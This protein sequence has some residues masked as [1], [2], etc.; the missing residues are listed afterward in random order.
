MSAHNIYVTTIP[1]FTS[2]S[3]LDAVWNIAI[4]KTA[5][6]IKSVEGLESSKIG[7]LNGKTRKYATNDEGVFA[8]ELVAPRD[9][10][11][12]EIAKLP[13]DYYTIKNISTGKYL[14]IKDGKAEWIYTDVNDY[15][16]FRA[17]QFVDA[18]T[19]K[20]VFQLAVGSFYLNSQSPNFTTGD[21]KDASSFWTIGSEAST[22]G[23]YDSEKT[24]LLSFISGKWISASAEK[25]IDNNAN[26]CGINQ[27]FKIASNEYGLTVLTALSN[28]FLLAMK[29][30]QTSVES[31]PVNFNN[32]FIIEPVGE[33]GFRL[34]SA[35]TGKYVSSN[36]SAFVSATTD[37]STLFYSTTTLPKAVKGSYDVIGTGLYSMKNLV[38]SS[39]Q[40]D[41]ELQI[42]RKLY[43]EWEMVDVTQSWKEGYYFIKSQLF[44][45]YLG[46][47]NGKAS[48][49][50]DVNTLGPAN[51]IQIVPFGSHLRLK[52][53]DLYLS[54]E[55]AP[56][57]TKKE[58]DK[59]TLFTF[60]QPEITPVVKP[61][62]K[63]GLYSVDNFQWASCQPGGQLEVNRGDFKEWEFIEVEASDKDD[64]YYF[65]ATNFNKYLTIKDGKASFEP[66][67]TANSLFRISELKNRHFKMDVNDVYLNHVAPNFTTTDRSDIVTAKWTLRT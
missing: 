66:T 5:E 51:Y 14:G 57:Y 16:K 2:N 36:P 32:Y 21:S 19:S 65:K 6:I 38:W 12:V 22:I 49:K 9:Q 17:I 61:T 33:T 18:K 39:C 60:T 23:K 34:K 1:P 27:E 3:K 31:A 15:D 53:G 55:N 64:H 63:T 11:F 35:V 29:G 42:D 40:P 24:C 44:N 20:P 28:G 47:E 59:S 13:N 58:D 52:V 4:T 7:L 30:E 10:D 41:G 8:N 48:F 25:K 26:S 56:N 50:Y 62:E 46:I 45:K 67:K 54:V 37:D 43:K